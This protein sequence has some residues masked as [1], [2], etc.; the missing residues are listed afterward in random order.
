M[1]K[2]VLLLLTVAALVTTGVW[3][4][5]LSQGRGSSPQFRFARVERGSLTATVSATGTLNAVST[6]VVGSQVSGQIKELFVDFNSRVRRGELVARIDPA[7]FEAKVNQAKADV[8]NARAMVLNQRAT[9]QRARAD[10]QNARAAIATGKATT[11]RAR[12]LAV[13]ARRDF[14][15]KLDLFEK[16]L[17]AKSDRDSAQT[18]ND[19]AVAQLDA[20]TAQEGSTEAG[21]AA[22]TASAHVVEAQLESAQ[23]ALRQKEAA[24]VQAQIDL[25]NTF[26][27]APV[28]GVVVS[29]NVDVGQ[30]VAAS[31][32]APILFSIAQDLTRMQLETSVVEADIGRVKLSDRATFTVDAFPGEMFEGT[33][34]QI[35]KAPQT[36][37]NVV[38]YTVVVAV[39]NRDGKLL[40]GMTANVKLIVAEKTNVLKVPNAAL[41][42]RPA[43]A[44]AATAGA[45][46]GEGPA[47]AT[48]GEGT[49]GDG[50]PSRESPRE[51]LIRSLDLTAEQQ[52]KV[53]QILQEGRQQRKALRQAGLPEPERKAQSRQVRET[54]HARLREVL[55][56]DQRNRYDQA[57]GSD[58]GDGRH[59]VPG[60]VWVLGPDGSP[61]PIAL[62]LG[63]ADR[64][65]TEVLQGD[66][67]EGQE[68]IVGAMA[69]STPGT[70]SGGPRLRL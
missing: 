32:Q 12:V 46:T 7:I 42:F 48:K 25:A 69:R 40:P 1:I 47:T 20:S 41:R 27:R 51:R 56:A 13:D 64:M 9:L 36:V 31:L 37:Q 60:R 39:T 8:E 26:I 66:V 70:A 67:K 21:L 2:R 49:S 23:A 16:G 38:T 18:A 54:T 57:A 59:G 28:D 61:K 58:A 50:E 5:L 43:T 55:N 34:G 11:A 6:V 63:F 22:A 3:G 4:Y 53:D 52:R 33:V 24:L 35:R 19:A 68:V 45:A 10:I 17:I 30:T 15:R 44:D 65:T 29:R 14:D 62:T